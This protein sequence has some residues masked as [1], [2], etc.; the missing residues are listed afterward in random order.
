MKDFNSAD[1]ERL[2][3]IYYAEA[4]NLAFALLGE[5]DSAAKI[6]ELSLSDAAKYSYN[7]RK[8]HKKLIS[9]TVK[10]AKA[11]TPAGAKRAKIKRR[12]CIIFIIVLIV[13]AIACIPLI[14]ITLKRIKDRE[15]DYSDGEHIYL[16]YRY[17]RIGE[18]FSHSDKSVTFTNISARRSLTVDETVYSGYYLIT[19]VVSSSEKFL[20]SGAAELY[21]Y[22]EEDPLDVEDVEKITWNTE[23]SEAL[24]AYMPNSPEVFSE[25][26]GSDSVE[27]N[28]ELFTFYYVY[29]LTQ[30]LYGRL[31]E[32]RN[33]C[34]EE[35][36][37]PLYSPEIQVYLRELSYRESNLLIH[38]YFIFF[39]HEII[40][41]EELQ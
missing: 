34:S 16:S 7:E 25:K 11:A 26:E 33:T 31:Y 32:L 12:I 3:D 22:S 9:F 23:L 20:Q 39:Y 37:S 38:P 21:F 1:F 14:P 29:D 10:N 41:E 40:F 18:T 30:Q 2:K 28:E 6:T 15:T 24:T 36:E 19:T 5:S 13:G 27:N 4:Y 17:I 8:F 35:R